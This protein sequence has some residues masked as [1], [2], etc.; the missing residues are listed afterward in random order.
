MTMPPRRMSQ[1]LHPDKGLS[2]TS[3]QDPPPTQILSTIV[4]GSEHPTFGDIP[5]VEVLHPAN[6]TSATAVGSSQNVGGTSSTQTN[7]CAPH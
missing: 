4:E 6:D 5:D 2:Q 7:G 3:T 1:H